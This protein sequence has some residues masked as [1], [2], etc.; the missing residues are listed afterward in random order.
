MKVE[1]K[2]TDIIKEFEGETNNEGDFFFE[3]IDNSSTSWESLN[4]LVNKLIDHLKV[5]GEF[6]E[7]IK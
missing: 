5:N 1:L 3:I 4:Y 7:S 6:S 2:R